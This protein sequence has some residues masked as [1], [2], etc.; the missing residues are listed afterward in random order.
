MSATLDRIIEEVRQLPPDEQRQLVE[1]LTAIVPAP[2]NEDERED[3][4]ERELMAEGIL[5]EVKPLPDDDPEFYAYR[6]VTV[7]GQPVSETI[8]EERR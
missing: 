6:P 7:T 5:G 8:I 3:E 1:R 4:F 2:P